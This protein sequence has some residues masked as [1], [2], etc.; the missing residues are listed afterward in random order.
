MP[1][2]NKERLEINMRG[3]CLMRSRR[4]EAQVSGYP[5]VKNSVKT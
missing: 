3:V 4:G 1:S 2:I 5:G